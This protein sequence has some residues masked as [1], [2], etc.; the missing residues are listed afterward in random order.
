[1][2]MRHTYKDTYS[3][4]EEPQARW[5]VLC[6]LYRLRC[7]YRLLLTLRFRGW[8]RVFADQARHSKTALIGKTRKERQWQCCIGRSIGSKYRRRWTNWRCYKYL[9]PYTE[10]VFRDRGD[11]EDGG[12]AGDEGEHTHTYTQSS[13]LLSLCAAIEKT[14]ENTL[15]RSFWQGTFFT[16]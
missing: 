15:H 1:M 14:R 9:L 5:P 10:S 13:W 3:L 7:N 4:A 6:E 12:Q 2:E 16:V 8:Y 11:D